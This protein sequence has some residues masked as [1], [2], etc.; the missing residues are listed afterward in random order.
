LRAAGRRVVVIEE[1][2]DQAEVAAAEGFPVII[3][4]AADPEVLAQAEL[5]S[6]SR[7]L[8]TLPD[9]FEAGQVVEQARAARADLPVL[10]RAHNE[11]EVAHLSALGADAVVVAEAEVARRFL[12]LAG[13]G[14]R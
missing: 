2:A 9:V 13:A 10:V 6:A 1:R 5:A 14:G 3:G 8:V 11:E 7:L 12:A 4:N